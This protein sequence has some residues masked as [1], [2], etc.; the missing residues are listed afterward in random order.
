[1]MIDNPTDDF[2]DRA[3][4]FALDNRNENTVSLRLKVMS[5]LAPDSEERTFYDFALTQIEAWRK[6]AS[7]LPSLTASSTPS[8]FPSLLAGEQ[9]SHE[10]I[11][12]FHA[13]L[14]DNADS[15]IDLTAGLGVDFRFMAM[16][17]AAKGD[18]CMAV[19]MDPLKA[20]VLEYNLQRA[21][22]SGAR[23]INGESIDFLKKLH[24][25]GVTVDLLF[26]D[27]ARRDSEG[28][29]LFDPAACSP[30]LVGNAEL[31]FDVTRRALIKNSPMLDVSRALEIYP[32][33]SRVYV[34]G[35]RNECKEVLVELSRDRETPRVT[36]VDILSDGTI[37]HFSIDADR[38]HEGAIR[39]F[40]ADSM[41][42]LIEGGSLYLYEP[43]PS[44]MKIAPWGALS[45]EMPVAKC[46]TNCHLFFSSEFIPDFP[47][48]RLKVNRQVGNKERKSLKVKRRN[49]VSRNHPDRADTIASRLRLKPSTASDYLYA[50][51]VGRDEKP[52]L[53]DCT[54]L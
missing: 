26:A 43:S 11:A 19:E 8:L 5:K 15:L 47:G 6:H 44:I 12:R 40:D 36:A 20:R 41:T 10:Q 23:V 32:D 17:V 24:A 25:E 1:M 50:L 18:R 21:G 13:S 28:G 4:A 45:A 9:A 37:R 46:S 34:V 38:L 2:F 27:P 29:R 35:V 42:S 53:L 31:M 51:T 14:V 52:L 39:Y 48:R 49:V 22:V 33:V 16:A 54:E 30:D 3:L 7:K